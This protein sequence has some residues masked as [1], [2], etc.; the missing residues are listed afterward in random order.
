MLAPDETGSFDETI[1]SV[2]ETEWAAEH[3]ATMRDFYVKG[4]THPDAGLSTFQ[5]GDYFNAGKFLFYPMPLKGDNI[6]AQEMINASG[7]PDL[8]VGE[9]Y[10]Q[11]KV[12][13]TTHAGGSM[14][15]IPMLSEYPV[16]AMK[17]INLMHSNSKLVNMMLFGVEGTHWEFEDDGRVNIINNAWYSATAGA[18]T[19]G[20]IML[21][22]VSNVEDPLK[23]KMLVEYSNDSVNHASLGFRFRTEPVAAELTA[24]NAVADAMSRALFTGYVD[25]AVELPV[26]IE[27]LKAAGLDTILA[28]VQAQYVAWKAAKAE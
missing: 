21:Q 6:K 26:Y 7:N 25:P 15:A 27:S 4:Y 16:H 8:K 11:P 10:G 1:V 19:M 5:T 3:L 17:Y 2:M 22:A 18:W 13:I 23:N 20:D 14:L 12:N 24:I 28:E 9:V